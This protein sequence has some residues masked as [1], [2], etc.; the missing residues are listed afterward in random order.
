M[1]EEVC[2]V[3]ALTHI[4][5]TPW[6]L[7][8]LHHLRQPKHFSE[9]RERLGV[10]PTLL[11]R[12]LRWLGEHGLVQRTEPGYRFARY[13]LTQ[14]GQELLPIIDAL[15]MWSEK[16]LLRRGETASDSGAME[17]RAL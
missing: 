2:P 3:A 14:A 5:G 12:R 16:W 9:L 6:T 1:T 7:Q 8:I 15:A 17:E 13:A 10:S 4:L 11:S